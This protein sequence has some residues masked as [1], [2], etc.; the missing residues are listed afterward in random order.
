MDTC[1]ERV[2]YADPHEVYELAAAVENWPRILP[3]YRSVRVVEVMTDGS[4]AVEM[5]AR[6]EVLWSLGVPLH[7][8]AIQKVQ[9]D[10]PR[11]TFEHIGGLT[12]GMQ[13]AWTFNV[14]AD[15]AL[16]VQIRH[17]F[18]PRWPVPDQ[19]VRLVV[20]DYFVNGVAARTLRCIGALAEARSG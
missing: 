14:L 18:E 4:R 8:L 1:I 10:V 9:P 12:R 7:W 17:V 6:R 19:L 15:G 16:R 3:H 20:G 11:I 5:A 2:V 13:V